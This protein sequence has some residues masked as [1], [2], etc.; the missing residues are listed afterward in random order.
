MRIFALSSIFTQKTA[1][2]ELLVTDGFRGYIEWLRHIHHAPLTNRQKTLHHLH[3]PLNTAPSALISTKPP[4]TSALTPSGEAALSPMSLAAAATPNAA[5]KP[6]TSKPSW[7]TY[8]APAMKP[9][10]FLANHQSKTLSTQAKPVPVRGSCR[11][12]QFLIPCSTLYSSPNPST[13][14]SLTKA[15]RSNGP[16]GKLPIS[17]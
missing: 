4:N 10:S 6:P 13:P 3:R 2:S 14:S 1:A 12:V 16:L 11:C 9:T 8:S 17:T 7:M 15:L 5:T